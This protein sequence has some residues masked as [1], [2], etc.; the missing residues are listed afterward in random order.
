MKLRL[1]EESGYETSSGLVGIVLN[2]VDHKDVW[3]IP[4]IH[5]EDVEGLLRSV[6]IGEVQ[7]IPGKLVFSSACLGA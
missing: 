6:V 1:G 4:L 2:A 5:A 3:S 7:F